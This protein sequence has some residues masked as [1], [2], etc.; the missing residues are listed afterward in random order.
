MS[1]SELSSRKQQSVL[2][3]A[4]G[5][6]REEI[7]SLGVAS[8]ATISR[9]RRDPEYQ[10]AVQELTGKLVD[11][12]EPLFQKVKV[13]LAS[14]AHQSIQTLLEAQNAMKDEDGAQVPDWPVRVRAATEMLNK[15]NVA[16][17]VAAA[18]GVDEGQHT[19]TAAAAVIVIKDDEEKDVDVIEGTATSS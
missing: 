7:V 9:W 17:L 12:L 1:S 4:T 16:G 18:K 13:E 11:S 10:E 19:A 3:E 5:L 8:T 2:L 15:L 6:T 14:G